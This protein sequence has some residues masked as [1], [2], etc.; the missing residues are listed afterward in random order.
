MIPPPKSRQG[1]GDD[2]PRPYPRSQIGNTLQNRR[3]SIPRTTPQRDLASTS[4]QTKAGLE[5]IKNP[6]Q[7][8]DD[9]GGVF[10]YSRPPTEKA[11]HRQVRQGHGGWLYDSCCLQARAGPPRS[12]IR[13]PYRLSSL[14]LCE[15]RKLLRYI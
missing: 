7:K 6:I 2:R 1:L 8:R 14:R 9:G 12:R 5:F 13:P 3:L 4:E 11:V 15:F 10:E